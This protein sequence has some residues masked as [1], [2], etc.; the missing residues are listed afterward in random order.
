[1]QGTVA[2]E[3]EP[4]SPAPRSPT[5]R[6]G[7]PPPTPFRGRTS[8]FPKVEDNRG[9]EQFAAGQHG[10]PGS[11]GRE[12]ANPTP[13]RTP[14]AGSR[15]FVVGTETFG[16]FSDAVRYKSRNPGVRMTGHNTSAEAER[17]VAAY[18]GSRAAGKGG[19]VDS[20]MLAQVL[21][22]QGE[23]LSGTVSHVL[24]RSLYAQGQQQAAVL[25]AVS[26]AAQESARHNRQKETTAVQ[27]ALPDAVLG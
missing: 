20:E 16:N 9:P 4:W 19:A 6:T 21:E 22:A 15:V 3:D 1:V 24:E 8:I 14:P 11:A 26:R 2:T 10:P 7:T 13:A 5:P 23:R 18:E 17:A 25:A 27:E 12:L